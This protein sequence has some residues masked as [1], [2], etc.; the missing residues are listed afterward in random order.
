MAKKGQKLKH[1]DLDFKLKV[2]KEK[3][4]GASYTFLERKYGKPSQLG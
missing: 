3:Q 1:Y 2:V 4:L